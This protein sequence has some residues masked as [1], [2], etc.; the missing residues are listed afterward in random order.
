M[1]C[2]AV[3]TTH[4]ILRMLMFLDGVTICA[5][6]CMVWDFA[7]V[8]CHSHPDTVS[9]VLLQGSYTEN[10]R[11]VTSNDGEELPTMVFG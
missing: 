1:Y 7:S 11:D 4:Q 10:F 3:L 5:S 9:M 6:S 8:R 2:F